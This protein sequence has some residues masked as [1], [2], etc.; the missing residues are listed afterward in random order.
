VREQTDIFSIFIE[1]LFSAKATPNFPTAFNI[2]IFSVPTTSKDRSKSNPTG[3]TECERTK[4]AR[5]VDNKY[6]SNRSPVHIRTRS[7]TSKYANQSNQPSQSSKSP[8]PF[9]IPITYARS[10][11]SKHKCKSRRS[12]QNDTVSGGCSFGLGRANGLLGVGS[13]CGFGGEF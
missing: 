8:E 13:E 2:E 3:Q 5:A 11:P 9:R 10:V 6:R 4:I 12:T 7:T 1:G